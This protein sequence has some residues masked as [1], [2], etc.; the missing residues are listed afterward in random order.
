MRSIDLNK[1]KVLEIIGMLPLRVRSEVLRMFY[2][3][4]SMDRSD[5][6]YL[7]L[8]QSIQC[9]IQSGGLSRREMLQ[10]G[11]L[12]TSGGLL[13]LLFPRSVDAGGVFPFGFWG[14]GS[15]SQAASAQTYVD[16]VFSMYLYTGTGSSQTISNGVNLAAKG[17]MIWLKDRGSTQYHNLVDTIRGVTPYL[18][19]N[20]TD[21]EV[22][23]AARIQ[24]FNTNGFST[25]ANGSSNGSLYSSWTFRK[26]P[27]F[28][29]IVTW[30]GDGAGSRQIY[31]NLQIT[32][33]LVLA[34]RR[35]AT[36]N[37]TAYFSSP[38][39]LMCLNST[40]S[41]YVG[42]IAGLNPNSNYFMV[43]ASSA[44]SLPGGEVVNNLNVSGAQYI[45]YLF[46]HDPSADGMIQCGVTS[47]GA[48]L[49]V[50]L[51]WEPQWIL[52]K[53][54]D[55]V[56]G[57]SVRDSARGW[58]T[59]TP[60][61]YLNLESSAIEGNDGSGYLRPTSN[62]LKWGPSMPSRS[63]Y[64]YVAIR[65]PNKPPTSATQVFG[66]ATGISNN[67]YKISAVGIPADLALLRLRTVAESASFA[68]RL[69]GS[70]SLFGPAN[71]NVASA[72]N[73]KWDTMDGYYANVSNMGLYPNYINY[74]FRRA[75]GFLDVV[76]INSLS[77]ASGTLKHNLGVVPEFVIRK[78]RN[79][80]GYW[81]VNAAPTDLLNK[82][83]LLHLTDPLSA[84]TSFSSI[85]NTALSYN[86]G[87]F[88]SGENHV[89]YLFA[90]KVG[91][92][93]VGTYTGNGSSSPGQT[94]SC[95]FSGGARF[96]LIKR[97]DSAGDWFVWDTYR[98]IT[99]S[100]NDPHISLNTTVT[101]V[102]T[103]DS[104]DPAGVGFIVKQNAVTN[105]NVSG[106]T[107][108]FLAIA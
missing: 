88:T 40:S 32:P 83:L 31:H 107:Y 11:A 68:S 53:W 69:Q 70:E 99:A 14:S 105:I 13:G 10:L 78:A 66:L 3:A 86:S 64:F 20:V 19:S 95:G 46:A 67:P 55:G 48:N 41:K 22:G 81:V 98:G 73:V 29:D 108:L 106:A 18:A 57:W 72:W 60:N 92:S 77:S 97:T 45:A 6:F 49:E 33:G 101:E 15:R 96:I 58:P 65:R 37:W 23:S 103:D 59:D 93:K 44:V 24:S 28:F 90:T 56:E 85:T 82:R 7:I 61:Q 71:T 35:D 38:E 4:D 47:S 17:G 76:C 51:G 36:S 104:I 87:V 89:L 102:A 50:N 100:A 2:Q 74:V 62:G 91:I 30:T 5:E 34:K 94:I 1:E 42:A 27:K 63:N 12:I 54:A 8:G 21:A 79:V 39:A 43:W 25:T 80:S 75:P 84:D 26:A 9:M 52:M 16:D